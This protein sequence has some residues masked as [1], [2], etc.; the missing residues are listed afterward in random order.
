MLR[1]LELDET[2]RMIFEPK[3]SRHCSAPNCP[4]RTPTGPATLEAYRKVFDSVAGS[5]QSGTG[6]LQVPEFYEDR[7]GELQCVGPGICSSCVERWE[8][9]HAELR[10]KAWAMLPN[11]FGLTG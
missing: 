10:K 5:S 9:G 6:V 8:S 1:G 2:H 11:V 7:G 4:S 3:S